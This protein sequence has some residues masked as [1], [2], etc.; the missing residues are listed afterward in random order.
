MIKEALTAEPEKRPSAPKLR[1]GPLCRALKEAISAEPRS[2]HRAESERR[3]SVTSLGEAHC[4]E[5][6]RRPCV[7]SLR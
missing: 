3:R 2:D 1:G 5:P 6:E 7:S 4:V